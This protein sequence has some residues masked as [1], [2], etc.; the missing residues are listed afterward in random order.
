MF[1]PEIEGHTFRQTV[2]RGIMVVEVI[3]FA[4]SLLFVLYSTGAFMKSRKKEYGLLMTLGISKQKLNRLLIIENT[5]IGLASIITGIL[6]G[7]LLANL[8]IMGFSQLLDLDQSLGFYIAPKALLLTFIAYF[9]MFEFNTLL[10]VWTLRTNAIIDLFR[11]AK[12]PKKLPRFSWTISIL[13]I[14]SIGIGYYLAWT[15]NLATIFG[16][17]IPILAFVIP[18]TYF[19]FTQGMLALFTGLKK[20]KSFY[21][22]RTNILTI[23][24]MIYKLKDHAR[25]LFFVTILS[26]VAFTASGVLYGVFQSAADEAEGYLPQSV[27][28]LGKG[29]DGLHAIDPAISEIESTF[30]NENIE[31]KTITIDG[32]QGF[33]QATNAQSEDGYWL[34]IYAFSDYQ[35]LLQLNNEPTL[36]PIKENEILVL[37]P[38]VMGFEPEEF[39]EQMT[40][41]AENHQQ[42]YTV[43]DAQ[44]IVNNNYFTRY[45]AVLSDQQYQAFAAAATENEQ[46]RYYAMDIANWERH[47]QVIADT[48]NSISSDGLAV[49]SQADFYNMLKETMGYTLFFGLFISVLFFL[50]A[51]S[52]LYF[53]MYQDMDKDIDQYKALYR[54]GLTEKE[55]KKIAT[56]Q[57]TSLFF[58]PF[59]LAMVHAAFAFKALQNMLNGSILIPSLLII[60]GYL[61]VHAINFSV[62]RKIY[63][64]KMKHVI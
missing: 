45:T 30:N 36:T 5:I 53:R 52:I 48:V 13:S 27:S 28:V 50:A 14:L 57:M 20:K 54:I 16:R 62:I 33:L 32:V 12:A 31:Y 24:D 7:I 10:V 39:P 44:T 23:S 60:T 6:F 22:N 15:A 17:M 56:K 61:L 3:I 55:M 2:Q 46:Y 8:F 18:G 11:S 63:I 21:F 37:T 42:A 51:G 59:V 40:V 19:L 49:D 26:A 41:V 35:Q 4:F 29:E 43:R 64:T 9:V 1:H 34:Q 47:S 25:L 58:I 38:K